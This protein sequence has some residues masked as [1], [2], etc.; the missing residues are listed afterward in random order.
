LYSPLVENTAPR[1]KY[2]GSV[3]FA[4]QCYYN[5]W[6]ASRALRDRGWRADVLN[7]DPVESQQI[8]YHG[9][10]VRFR[11][12]HKRE[13]ARQLAFFVRALRKY[14]VFHFSNNHGLQFG[15]F[16][17]KAFSPFGEAAEIKLLRRLGKKIVYS[18]NGCL[19][20]V[21]QTSFAS[22]GDEP[23]CNACSWKDVPSVCSDERNLAW[24]RL[25]NSLADYQILTGGNR[26]DYNVDPSIHE[27]PEMYCLHPEVWSPDLVVPANDRLPYRPSTVKIYHGVGNFESRTVS[28]RKVNIKSTH[29]Y[30]PLIERLQR[31]GHDVELVFFTGIPNKDLLFY[32]VQCD[33]FVDM[34][35]FGWFGA[36]VREAM[37]LGKPVVCYLRP[38]WLESARR[39]IPEYIDELP[40]V[41]ATPDTAYEV[42]RDLVEN[43]EKRREIG[44]RSREF[45]LRWHTP[46]VAARR[47]EEIYLSL[48]GR[49][50]PDVRDEPAVVSEASA[51]VLHAS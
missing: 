15:P 37:M 41:S 32:Q 23:V 27:V 14:E 7:W 45:A 11:Y 18:N 36:S 2:V 12:E 43:P 25:R 39:E 1:A 19:D 26:A 9:E 48:L 44:R 17:R 42:V 47:L 4:G 6:Y 3:L 40:I 34:L 30:L 33:I 22:W 21:S 31:E 8:Y 29:L 24:G 38:E 46:P 49:R 5:A 13:V 16:I 35:T 50:G 51:S 28:E 10:D 20:G